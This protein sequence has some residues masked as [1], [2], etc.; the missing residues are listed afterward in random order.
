MLLVG[1]CQEQLNLLET[2]INGGRSY[3][4]RAIRKLRLPVCMKSTKDAAIC[5]G[6]I[7][8]DDL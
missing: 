5:D 2:H 1:I 3:G 6:M 4:I 7:Y 8:W